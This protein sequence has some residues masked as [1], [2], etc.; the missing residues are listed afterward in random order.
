MEILK[1][2]HLKNPMFFWVL[3][4]LTLNKDQ[5]VSGAEQALGD[6]WEVVVPQDLGTAGILCTNCSSS[7]RGISCHIHTLPCWISSGISPK[8]PQNLCIPWLGI[9]PKLH[10]W[11]PALSQP[12]LKLLHPHFPWEERAKLP[13]KM[14]LPPFGSA[15]A[16]ATALGWISRALLGMLLELQPGPA[17]LG[18]F[19]WLFF[20]RIIP[21]IPFISF[22]SFPG[23]ANPVE[24][25][26]RFLFPF[27][28]RDC[29]DHLDRPERTNQWQEKADFC[30]PQESLE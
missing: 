26:P 23:N 22:K 11:F 16:L 24:S 4:S 10:F 29:F 5:G 17:V 14:I 28:P 13:R 3:R 15:P 27:H 7:P 9:T 19:C 6:A 25:F 20:A 1:W 30:L 12:W 8:F 21:C 18:G 2:K